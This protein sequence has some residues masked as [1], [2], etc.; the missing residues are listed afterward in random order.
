MIGL[1]CV[2][3]I[4]KDLEGKTIWMGF[5][6]NN[7]KMLDKEELNVEFIMKTFNPQGTY[8]E[9]EIVEEFIPDNFKFLYFPEEEDFSYLM[10]KDIV[11]VGEKIFMIDG[12]HE[13][14]EVWDDIREDGLYPIM[15]W[16]DIEGRLYRSQYKLKYEEHNILKFKVKNDDTEYV[17]EDF[18]YQQSY[19]SDYLKQYNLI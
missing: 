8:K 4:L 3:K 16:E 12:V 2:I 5:Y 7:K 14:I 1:K 13:V 19:L 6:L 18:N 9:V 11:E 15:H 17:W 10:D